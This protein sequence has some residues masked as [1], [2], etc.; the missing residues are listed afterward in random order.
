MGMGSSIFGLSITSSMV[1]PLLASHGRGFGKSRFL[2][3]WLSSCGLLPMVGFLPWII[4]CSGA[5][6]LGNRCCMCRCSAE[7]VDNLLIHCPVAYSLWVHMLQAFRI[8][9]VMPGLVE[10]LVSCWRNWL[11]NFSSDIW[12]MVPGCL[13]WVVWLERNQHSFKDLGGALDQLQTLNQNTLFDWARCWGSSNCS[14][15]LEFLSS[16]RSAL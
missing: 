12:N 9:W 3:G 14:S 10:S 8:Q 5:P 2:R 4:W 1:H 16:L 6:P 11:G 7:F 15:A 13:M